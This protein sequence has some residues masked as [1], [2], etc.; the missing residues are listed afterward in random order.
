MKEDK[1]DKLIAAALKEKMSEGEVPYEFG[2]WES[3]DRKR[4]QK[5]RKV[6][7]LWLTGL[8]ASL[9][10]IFAVTQTMYFNV[11]DPTSTDQVGLADATP[12]DNELP[13]ENSKNTSVEESVDQISA[14]ANKISAPKPTEITQ[15]SAT[16]NSSLIA[17]NSSGKNENSVDGEKKGNQS[18][19]ENESLIAE[20]TSSETVKVETAKAENQK[21]ASESENI[22]QQEE[23]I[24]SEKLIAG[25]NEKSVTISPEENKT[26]VKEADFPEIA[27]TK[28]KVNLGMEVSPGFGGAQANN[29]TTNASTI[30]LGMLVDIN[31]PG[32]LV[33]GSGIGLNYLSQVN[34]MQSMNDA[35]GRAYPQTD[36]IQVKQVQVELPVILKYP[37][38]KNNSI[39]LQ[40]GFSNY[41]AINQTA[42]QES[43]FVAQSAVYTKNELGATSFAIQNRAVDVKSPLESNS[44]KFYPFATLNVGVNLRVAE[45]K[46]A[47]YVVM[48]FYNYQVK[49]ISGY[50]DTYGLFGASLK[51]NFGGGEN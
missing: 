40:A 39:S 30:G 45:S 20:K 42:E 19:L 31:L 1:L 17:K 50:G 38:T 5:K 25:S 18:K 15:K 43:Q 12:L 48:P 6:V 36:K 16:K 32:K 8:A 28:T 2:T 22:A 33:V 27:E 49:Q 14:E 44:G 21:V 41:Y 11:E 10:L 35:F 29:V 7:G 9:A 13:V 47:S 4:N 34:E 3:F 37:I 23:V 46:N 51:V 24:S 26:Y